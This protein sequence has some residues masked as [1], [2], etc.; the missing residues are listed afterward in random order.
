MTVKLNINE[1]PELRAYI[2]DAIKG[3]VVSIAREEILNILKEVLKGKLPTVD[4][5]TILRD[6]VLR[7]VKN[8]LDN[9]GW[10]KPSFVQEE[11]RK[12]VQ[13]LVKEILTKNPIL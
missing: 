9:G 12:E 13:K 6:E 3:Q 8:Q 2:K 4:P 1:D 7:L 10:N 11:A 5:N